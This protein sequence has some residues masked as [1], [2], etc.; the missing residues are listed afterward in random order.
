MD[1]GLMDFSMTLAR[2]LC[3]PR[4]QARGSVGEIK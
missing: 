1:L 2:R 3:L 4:R